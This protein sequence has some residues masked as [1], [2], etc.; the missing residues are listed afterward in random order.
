[1]EAGFYD[2]AAKQT[3]KSYALSGWELTSEHLAG[4]LTLEL[5]VGYVG[6]SR[7]NPAYDAA[8]KFDGLENYTDL[9]SV[10]A[11]VGM[12]SNFAALWAL[13]TDGIQAGHMKLH[14]RKN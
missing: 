13:T 11:A 1:M 2:L 12:S 9:C 5:P 7:S 8:F 10:L 4:E 14:H 6:G 3:E